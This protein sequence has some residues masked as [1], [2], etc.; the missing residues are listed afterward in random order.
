MSARYCVAPAAA[1][2]SSTW[3][4]R[5]RASPGA[6]GGAGSSGR[7]AI[8]RAAA[9]SASLE[10]A[11]GLR[12]VAGRRARAGSVRPRTWSK[13]TSR[14][15]NTST[16]SG[17]VGPMRVRRAAL[18]LQLVAE[19]ADEAA[20]RSRTAGRRGCGALRGWRARVELVE[21]RAVSRAPPLGAAA[22]ATSR[23]PMSTSEVTTGRAA[24]R[25]RPGT[26]SASRSAR[27][28]CR[29]RRRARRRRR[30]VR[31]A[32]RSSAPSR[33]TTWARSRAALGRRRP[34]ADAGR[35]RVGPGRNVPGWPARCPRATC[36]VRSAASRK[37]ASSRA[38][39]SVAID[40][41]WNCTPQIG[42]GAVPSPI[43][44]PSSAH[45]VADQVLGQRLGDRQR[46]VADRPRSPAGCPA[47]RPL[48]W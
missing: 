46:V 7:R 14:S 24:R 47:N 27:R 10:P 41:G 33:R 23:S 8:S 44:T 15:A 21:D 1:G 37:F 31:R 36:A 13:A 40:S 4:S 5:R 18:G 28:R 30:A 3:P 35:P 26:R 9:S 12:L 32:P 48:P 34:R 6:S 19:V 29:A 11:L 22:I 39:C 25:W 2:G 42:R 38:P 16:A 17:I 20:S 43:T 45:A